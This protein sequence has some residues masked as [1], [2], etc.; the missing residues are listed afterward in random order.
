MRKVCT[1]AKFRLAE[2]GDRALKFVSNR[3]IIE[4]V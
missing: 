1:N 3:S 2:V 4:F